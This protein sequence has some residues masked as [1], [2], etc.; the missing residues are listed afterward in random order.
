MIGSEIINAFRSIVR[1]KLQSTISILGLG[2]GFGCIILLLALIIHETSFNRFI[3][4]HKNVYRILF[5]ETTVT[6][7]P[8]AEEM[9]REFPEVKDF[10]RFYQTNSIELH[11]KKNELV[12]DRNFGFSDPSIFRILGI[13]MISGTPAEAVTE[14]AISEKTARKYFGNSSPLGAVLPVKLNGSFQDLMVT[15]VYR[16]F[17]SGS[18][19]FPDFI[20]NIKLS[21]KMFSQYQKSLGAYGI[22]NAAALTWK[23]IEF[24]SFVVLDNGTDKWFLAQKMEKYKALIKNESTKDWKFSLQPVSEI[25]MKSRG[26]SNV[27]FC[28]VGNP[29]E[30]KYYEAISLVI[31][32]ISVINFILLTRAE[33]S[34]R[35]RELGTRKAF[36]AFRKTL[37]RQILVK[38]NLV[39]LI[40]LI[41]ATFVIDYGMSFINNTLNKT[42]D[43][44]VFYD[45]A[46]WLLLLFVVLFTGT[47][48]GLLIGYNFSGIPSILLLSGKTADYS[49]PGRW[50]Y[51]FLIFHFSIYIIL[52]ASVITVSKQIKYSLTSFRGINP[53][54]VLVCDLN[55][56]GL[57]KNF[58][59]I[60]GELEKIP[61]VIKTA[62][63]S[64]IP[65]FGNYLP[66]N[67]A[68]PDGERQ[69]FDGLIMGK[70][71]TELLGIEIKE[72]ES[73]GEFSQNSGVL[74]NESSALKYNLKAGDN[75]LGFNIRGIVRDF[76][77]HSLHTLIQPMVILQQN[78]ERMGLLA[79]KT[80][81]SNDA[82]IIAKLKELY[83]QISPDEIF[84]PG[85]LT[86][87]VSGFYR[88]ERNQ[89]KIIGVFS[90]LATL[91]SMMGLFG[92]ALISIAKRTKEIGIRKV[93][94]A[95]IFEVLYLINKDFI[96]WVLFSI[97]VAVPASIYLMEGWMNRFAYKTVLSWWIFAAAGLSAVLIAIITVSWQSWRAATRN[98]VEALRYE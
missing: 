23:D 45:P 86:D 10:F 41:P 83:N 30:L 3:P 65:P 90:L 62:G 20:A 49:R 56:D 91:L 79:I 54:N 81:R 63:G 24:L 71:M 97:V 48:S 29:D 33:I 32:L 69:R 78:P 95:S 96:K 88:R 17:P 25:Y 44:D 1:N 76:H 85:W 15:G 18:T 46:M 50:T 42:L 31:L 53:E 7:Y 5:G 39:A 77:A 98:P 51:S 52:V 43:N 6:Q 59:A 89:A 74:M 34:D 92:I 35:L 26:I 11:N 70:G 2:I 9:K 55:S 67:L 12:R 73:F 14:V 36:G 47:L 87:Q 13:K 19:L 37:R 66:V 60:C 40:S 57:K 8:L 75:Y 84:E 61:G 27:P 94:G 22:E 58:K 80:D 64:F 28:R 4:D 16:D 72:G 68:T 21:G 82:A 38:S 93:N